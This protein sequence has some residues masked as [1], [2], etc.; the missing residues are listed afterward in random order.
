MNFQEIQDVSRKTRFFKKIKLLQGFRYLGCSRAR[1]AIVLRGG[2]GSVGIG[3]QGR[4]SVLRH[5]GDA[6]GAIVIDRDG[7]EGPQVFLN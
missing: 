2:R 5:S 1:S 4:H 3:P 7:P 6:R